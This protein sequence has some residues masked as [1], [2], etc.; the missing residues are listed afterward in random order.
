[1]LR[2]QFGQYLV[3]GLDLFLQLGDPFLLGGMVEPRFRLKGSLPI[4]EKLHLP[5]VQDRGLEAVL[6]TQLRDRHLLQQ[7]PPQDGDLLFRRVVLPLLPSCVRSIILRGN[8]FSIFPLNRNSNTVWRRDR[9]G[10]EQASCPGGN[11]ALRTNRRQ[12]IGLERQK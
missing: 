8:A 6:V 4:L 5:A 1:M 2:H 10:A 3:F 9:S 11:P 7:M 12:R